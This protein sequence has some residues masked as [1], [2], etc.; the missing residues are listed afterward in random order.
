VRSLFFFFYGAGLLVG[1]AVI[2]HWCAPYSVGVVATRV[3]AA[4]RLLQ[5][6]DISPTSAPGQYVTHLV[7]PGEA[8]QPGDVSTFPHLLLSNGDLPIALPI[9]RQLV[10]QGV[11]AG[12]NVRICRANEAV[13]PSVPVRVLLCPPSEG[14]CIAIAVIASPRA[15]DVAKAFDKG[16][17]PF[18]ETTLAKTPC[19]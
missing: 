17:L 19:K 10:A 11:N 13:F 12:A 2:L 4:N 7:K 1:T 8:L 9:R 5:P 14:E 3:L 15:E 16:G 18:L 6:G